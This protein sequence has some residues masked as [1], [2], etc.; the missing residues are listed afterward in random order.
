MTQYRQFRDK[1]TV[2]HNDRSGNDLFCSLMLRAMIIP[3]AI[4]MGPTNIVRFI[5]FI[6]DVRKHNKPQK[7]ASYKR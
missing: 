6:S 4:S 7:K 5:A 2:L 3:T 1:D